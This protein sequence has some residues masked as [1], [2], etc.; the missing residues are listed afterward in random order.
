MKKSIVFSFLAAGVI[1]LQFSMCK[2]G[3]SGYGNAITGSSVAP[4]FWFQNPTTPPPSDTALF[5]SLTPGDTAFHLWAW[6]KFLS[7]TRSSEQIAPFQRLFQVDSAG[8]PIDTAGG[9]LKLT[10]SL[11]AVS[12]LPL[13]DKHDRALLYAIQINKKMYRFLHDYLS[14]FVRIMHNCYNLDISDSLKDLAVQDSLNK[15]KYDSLDFPVGSL[16]LKTAWIRTSDAWK[17]SN[18]YYNTWADIYSAN[19][20]CSRERVSLVGMHI[21][22]TVLNHPEF[23]W[24]TFEHDDLAPGYNWDTVTKWPADTSKPV[25]SNTDY[26]LYNK[27]TPMSACL[28][29]NLA[30]HK[31]FTNVFNMFPLGEAWSFMYHVNSSLNPPAD[32]LPD[33]LDI[34]DH[35]NVVSLNKSVHEHLEKVKGPWSHYFYK[36]AVWLNAAYHSF[37]PGNPNYYLLTDSALNG[38]RALSN[39]TMETFTQ[40]DYTGIYSTGSMSCFGCH[41]T[42]DFVNVKDSNNQL[43]YNL[44]ISHLFRNALQNSFPPAQK[45]IKPTHLRSR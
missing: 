41:A 30:M 19:G 12:H 13:Y 3:N 44:V 33:K 31:S 35:S 18:N 16:V 37:G 26:L 7:L 42:A 45:A 27:G 21:V 24:S 22:G 34:T 32:T 43:S 28:N 15:Y 17:D 39:I 23:I 36:G 38:G 40:T 6:Q 14:V 9:I 4:S 1:I 8:N 2:H 11:Q 10:D 5:T 29:T 25:L 20:K